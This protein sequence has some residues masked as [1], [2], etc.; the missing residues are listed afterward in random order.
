MDSIG[1]FDG[2]I[3]VDL[4]QCDIVNTRFDGIDPADPTGKKRKKFT[5]AGCKLSTDLERVYEGG[6]E[7]LKTP[8][9][10]IISPSLKPA[11]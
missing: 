7:I 1:D 6:L 3:K 5:T 2:V 4:K 9:T 10:G 8:L 11:E